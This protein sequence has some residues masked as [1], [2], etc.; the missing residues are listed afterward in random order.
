MAELINATMGNNSKYVAKTS[1][2]ETQKFIEGHEKNPNKDLTPQERGVMDEIVAALK[3]LNTQ[4]E[5]D[6]PNEKARAAAAIDALMA[7]VSA[8]EATGGMSTTKNLLE[9][10]KSRWNSI[11]PKQ[12]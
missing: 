11:T 8:H 12:G 10:V 1:A 2:S 6:N 4:A 5:S 9:E 7:G 3:S